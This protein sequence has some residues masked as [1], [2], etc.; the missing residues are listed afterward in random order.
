M[1]VRDEAAQ[2]VG[3][4]RR[5][6]AEKSAETRD[7][8]LDAAI[9]CLVDLGYART[10]TIEVAKRAGLSR[11][12]M[13]HHYPSKAELV[14]AAVAHVAE[15][16][17]TEFLRSVENFPPGADLVATVI[18]LLWENFSSPTSYAMLELTVAART[19]K[20]LYRLVQPVI[21]RYEEIIARKARE[22]FGVFARSPEAFEMSR[23]VIYYLMH[24]LAVTQILHTDQKEA[25]QFLDILKRQAVAEARAVLGEPRATRKKLPNRQ[26]GTR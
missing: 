19:D 10:T 17:I 9:D 5:T 1:F 16:R 3:T 21:S 8:L 23:R 26:R 15:R 24:G 12:A 2:T 14:T 22:L 25:R 6:Q 18:D 7:R 4:S 11:G 20:E 13:L